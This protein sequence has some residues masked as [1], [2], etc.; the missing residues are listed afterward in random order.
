[1]E[2]AV[3]TL[4]ALGEVNL[5][6]EILASECGFGARRPSGGKVRKACASLC[7]RGGIPPAFIAR[8]PGQKEALMIMISGG[9]AYG[10]DLLLLVGDPARL[11][12]RVFRQGDLL[13][14][15]APLAGIQRVQPLP[16]RAPAPDRIAANRG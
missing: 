2:L 3:P 10:P 14:L 13:V 8:G 16:T 12:G 7:I 6:G 1:M 15:D 5:A 4:K 11:R 9:R